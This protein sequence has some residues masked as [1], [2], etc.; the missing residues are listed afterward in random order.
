MSKSVHQSK[1][2]WITAASDIVPLLQECGLSNQFLDVLKGKG[3]LKKKNKIFCQS[4]LLLFCLILELKLLVKFSCYTEDLTA[5]QCQPKR[6]I[7]KY[8]RKYWEIEDVL[9]FQGYFQYLVFNSAEVSQDKY[10]S[11]RGKN[12]SPSGD[13]WI[14]GALQGREQWN[15]SLPPTRGRL[16][17]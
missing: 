13:A 4:H 3:S 6:W 8:I 14:L 1:K 9:F 15:D 17:F 10:G 5:A 11:R 7:K 2:M 12:Q 16:Q